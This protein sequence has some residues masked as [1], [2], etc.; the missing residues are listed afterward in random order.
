MGKVIAVANQKGGVG[1]TTTAVNLAAALAMKGRRVLLVDMDPQGNAT[2]GCGLEKEALT[3]SVYEVI[4][5]NHKTEAA[6]HSLKFEGLDILPANGNLIGAEVELVH[7]IGREYF[8]KRNLKSVLNTYHYIF[9]DCPPSLGLLTVNALTAA[10]GVIIPLQCEFYAM[11]GL[12]QLLRTL[13][14]IKHSVNPPLY[15]VGILLTMFDVRNNISHQVREEVCRHFGKRVF[16]TVIN[17]NVR[18]SE[19]PS[20]GR[21][22]FEYDQKC[23]GAMGYLALAEELIGREKKA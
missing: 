14:L 10:E 13:R 2:S 23:A 7:E 5:G 9:I 16:G 19:A 1:K 20:F 11:E 21:N 18:L 3:A 15:I 17:R 4:L 6:I 12:S 8:L 22:I